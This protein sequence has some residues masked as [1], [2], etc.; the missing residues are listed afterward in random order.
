M[1]SLIKT[2]FKLCARYFRR[3][4]RDANNLSE[5]IGTLIAK[6][7]SSELADSSHGTSKWWQKVKDTVKPANKHP[8]KALPLPP[9]VF[10]WFTD[11]VN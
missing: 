3:R 5:R 11:L 10:N 2:L 9:A 6:I 1:S 8:E 4:L 7:R